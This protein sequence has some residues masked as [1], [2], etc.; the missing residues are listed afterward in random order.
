MD[1]ISQIIKCKALHQIPV[2]I[3]F[4]PVCLG[5]AWN[6]IYTYGTHISGGMD[7]AC[8]AHAVSRNMLDHAD[9]KGL[10]LYAEKEATHTAYVTVVVG[11]P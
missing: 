10:T 6:L 4:C 7:A 9:A 5:C 3:R 1:S 11:C 2:R 8:L